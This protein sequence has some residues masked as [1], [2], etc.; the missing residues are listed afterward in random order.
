[1]ILP[2]SRLS[3]TK[4]DV[5][6][7]ADI[8]GKS[9]KG[10]EYILSAEGETID[11]LLE[12]PQL[13]PALLEQGTIAHCS[14]HLFFY[15]AVFNEMKG[16]HYQNREVTDYVASMLAA[17]IQGDRWRKIAFDHKETYDHL[18]D[19]RKAAIESS[20]HSSFLYHIHIGNYSLFLAGI[21]PEYVS[22][23]NTK[24]RFPLGIAHYDDIGSKGYDEAA[25]FNQ[26]VQ[27]GL[28][29]LLEE[30]ADQFVLVRTSLNKVKQRFS[31]S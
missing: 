14:P 24:K 23:S 17:F 5:V 8:L 1:M 13:Y 4:E 6:F 2:K 19:L 9:K 16:L 7:I 22:L 29:A 21:F 25:S 12:C 11:T 27:Y 30:L 28:T 10:K 26:S 20:S 15:V 3:L 31:S 18:F